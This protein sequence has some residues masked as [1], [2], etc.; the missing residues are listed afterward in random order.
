MNEL[1]FVFQSTFLIGI[2]LLALWLGKEALITFVAL[3]GILANLFVVKQ[4]TLFNLQVTASDAFAIGAVTGLNLLNE[5]YGRL[6][7]RKAL[8]IAF[9]A[10]V[11]FTIFSTIHLCYQPNWCDTSHLHFNAIL[12]NTPRIVIASLFSYFTSQSIEYR[13]YSLLK[14]ATNGR[15]LVLRNIITMTVSQGIDTILFSFLALYGIVGNIFDV[16]LFGYAIKIITI[17]S[18]SPFI[19]LSKYIPK[20]KIAS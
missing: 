14:T 17:T 9:G 6:S 19:W 10:T 13:L 5:Y 3:S 16:I 11:V 20:E 15:Y 18:M 7:T 1:I 12:G 8:Y 2:A 4:I